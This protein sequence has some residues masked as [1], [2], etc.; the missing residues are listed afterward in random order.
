MMAE[1]PIS[2]SCATLVETVKNNKS[3]VLHFPLPGP[4]VASLNEILTYPTARMVIQFSPAAAVGILD[5]VRNRILDWAIQ[6]ESEGVVG[7]GLTFTDAERKQAQSVM[8]T[9]NIY[10]NNAG[11]IGSGNSGDIDAEQTHNDGQLFA[12]LAKAIHAG[13]VAGDDRELL[14]KAVDRMSKAQADKGAFHAAYVD[15]VSSAAS[16]MTIVGPFLP[17]LLPFLK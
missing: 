13:I 10:G 11:H 17:A 16:Y 6:M 14:L 1:A 3:G 12:S 5:N 15:F 9:V 8:T 2:Q 7:E 4:L